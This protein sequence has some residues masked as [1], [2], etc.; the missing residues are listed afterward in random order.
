VRFWDNS[1]V[2][3]LLLQ[4]ERSSHAAA[5]LSGDEAMLVWT[6]TPVE[7]MSA[8]R[9]LARERALAEYAARIGEVRLGEHID[10]CHIVIAVETAK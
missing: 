5:W 9:R 4:Q 6:L 7:V 2:V 3:P 10:R 1:A 8:L